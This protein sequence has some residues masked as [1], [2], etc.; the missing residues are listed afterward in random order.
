MPFDDDRPVRKLGVPVLYAVV[1]E[2][3]FGILETFPCVREAQEAR[4][5]AA[6]F[7]EDAPQLPHASLRGN[8]DPEGTS[9]LLVGVKL[10]HDE[11][12]Q[13]G[14]VGVLFRESSLL[15]RVLFCG[16]VRS[17][18]DARVV[19]GDAVGV[20]LYRRGLVFRLPARKDPAARGRP[21]DVPAFRGGV[22]PSETEG[23]E[24]SRRDGGEE[25]H[26]GEFGERVERTDGRMSGGLR[27]PHDGRTNARS[28]RSTCAS[29]LLLFGVEVVVVRRYVVEA[30]SAGPGGV[31]VL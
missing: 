11:E 13:N 31:V 2:V 9:I 10:A 24:P 21:D 4:E 26:S 1:F 7:V 6:L 30:R 17:H 19:R 14:A 16:T 25:E 27:R 23:G 5:D 15:M 3:S 28:R 29:V 18:G 12:L 8:F 20:L 22:R